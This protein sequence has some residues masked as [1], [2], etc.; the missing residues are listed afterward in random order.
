M[1]RAEEPGL[2]LSIEEQCPKPHHRTGLVRKLLPPSP[3]LTPAMQHLCQEHT[4][5]SSANGKREPPSSTAEY[6]LQGGPLLTA[7]FWSI[8]NGRAYVT[9]QCLGCKENHETDVLGSTLGRRDAQVYK[10]ALT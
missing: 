6:I 3:P 7:P 8:L 9:W 4:L 2:R 5:A 1:G 10:P